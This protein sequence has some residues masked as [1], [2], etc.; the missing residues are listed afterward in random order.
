MRK[1]INV[2]M[3]SLALLLITGTLGY[4]RSFA[5]PN[6][7]LEGNADG[8]V[9]IPGNEPFLEAKNMVPGDNLKRTLI[10]NNKF[11]DTYEI[12][13]RA[14]RVTQ[15]EDDD[16]LEKLKLKIDYNNNLL[17]SGNATGEPEL[18]E[19]ISLGKVNPGESKELVAE[20]SLDGPT[21]GNEYKGKKG[22]VN[23]I[24][25]AIRIPSEESNQ[26]ITVPKT[27]DSGVLV[28]L[29]ISIICLI[30]LLLS[31]RKEKHL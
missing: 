8:I 25:T 10:L 18:E 4:A 19:N 1:V 2:F 15:K 14:E 27:G 22:D 31:N 17:Y 29:V 11:N 28:Y 7:E 16:L 21:T 24:F 12:F 30:L 26:N 5:Y 3:L 6:V 13:L 20:V 9:Y 23:W